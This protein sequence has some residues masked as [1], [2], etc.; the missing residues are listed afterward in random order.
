MNKLLKYQKGNAGIIILAV[1]V[2][3]ILAVWWL[4]QSGYKFPGQVVPTPTPTG[5]Q[6]VS[7]LDSASAQ[8]DATNLNQ[9]DP[10]I[11]QISADSNS[12]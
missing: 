11:N 1:V 4:I 9:M 6:N 12:F 7:E 3:V 2:L 8:L 10:G 5:I